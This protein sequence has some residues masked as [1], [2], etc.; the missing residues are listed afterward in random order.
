MKEWIQPLRGASLRC[1]LILL[2][3]TS[4]V[5]L[6]VTGADNT[7]LLSTDT[8]W[9]LPSGYAQGRLAT[10]TGT[11]E[12][13]GLGELTFSPADITTLRPDIFLPG[14]FSVFDVL[15]HLAETNG[16]ELDY[17]FDEEMQTHV[18]RSLSGLSGWWYD[19]HYQGGGFDKTVVRIDQ[20]PVKD[21]MS[22]L[23]YLEDPSRLEAINEHFR[24]QVA[25]LA[26]N[27]GVVIIPSVTLVSSTATVEFR[28]V[29]VS[30]HDSRTDVFQSGVIT[31]LDVLL[32]LGDQGVLAELGLDWR[33]EEGDIPIVDG[34]YVVAIQAEGFTPE[35][36]GSCVLTHQISG[37]TIAEYLAP[38]TH[39]MSHIHLTADLDV[40]VSPEAI[41]WLW[42]CL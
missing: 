9:S 33:E 26:E 3:M 41:E 14:H 8:G 30:A 16:F 34:Y 18:I 35:T 10:Q 24:E 40:L 32:S 20:F 38:H 31:T 36:T 39:T 6:V 28:D 15:V 42:I 2:L 29:A 11:L 25:R 23:L 37:E 13:R 4:L 27:E 12:I 1:S 7:S 19:A 5:P 22:I 21:G 17:A